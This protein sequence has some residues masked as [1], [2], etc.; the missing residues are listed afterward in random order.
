MRVGMYLLGIVGA[1]VFLLSLV[2]ALDALFKRGKPL[3]ALT[4]V[5]LAIFAYWGGEASIGRA[6]DIETTEYIQELRRGR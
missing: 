3:T 2:C 1:G 6:V 5:L 4:W